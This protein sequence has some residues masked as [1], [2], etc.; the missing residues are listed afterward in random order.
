MRT[1]KRIIMTVSVI[2]VMSVIAGFSYGKDPD[3]YG[4]N[5]V[6]NPETLKEYVANR[7]GTGTMKF[8]NLPGR[9]SDWFTMRDQPIARP[10]EVLDYTK[11]VTAEG[12]LILGKSKI[13]IPEK[14]IIGTQIDRVI[15]DI[16]WENSRYDISVDPKRIPTRDQLVPY[17]EGRLA[18]I[19]MDYA[20]VKILGLTP[21]RSIKRNNEF[22][23]SD[24]NGNW[25]FKIDPTKAEYKSAK[26]SNDGMKGVFVDTHGFNMIAEQAIKKKN[27]HTAIA[28]MDLPSKA[29]A[30][31]YLAQNKINCYGPCDRFAYQL[32]GYKKSDPDI[33]T[34]IGTAPIRHYEKGAVI[35]N[36]PIEISLDE[37]IVTQNTNK[38][39]PDQYCDTPTKYFNKLNSKYNLKL[40][41]VKVEADA[42][43]AQKVVEKAL[44]L[45]AL[46]IGVRV[47]NKADAIAV[48]AW[49][50]E[51]PDHRAVLFHSAIYEP[52]YEMFFRFPEQTSFG[53]LSPI[54]KK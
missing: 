23:A 7:R 8:T 15:R 1:R 19:L 41:L 22:Y 4:E 48:A 31:L 30:A 5:D 28:C 54:I 26:I 3:F 11:E 33:A 24:G 10:K 37:T 39:Y 18:A 47:W 34:I 25:T 46:V 6:N 43:K 2:F 27:I 14:S 42:G 13:I 9:G 49:L 32:L 29:E 40:R 52:G 53:D 35:G 50:E 38:G 21:S 20:Q 45:K 16:A 44:S 36:Q 17:M 12:V 51:N